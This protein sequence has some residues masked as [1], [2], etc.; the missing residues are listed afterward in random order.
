MCADG[1]Q[2]EAPAATRSTC[3][4][5][6]GRAACLL[7]SHESAHGLPARGVR[8]RRPAAPTTLTPIEERYD[9]L[10][11]QIDH[12]G[13]GRESGGANNN[14]RKEPR[15]RGRQAGRQAGKG[16]ARGARARD[17][18]IA[19]KRE[20]GRSCRRKMAETLSEREGPPKTI[21]KAGSTLT[22]RSIDPRRARSTLCAPSPTI[23]AYP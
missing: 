3:P 4:R 20:A 18:E 11:V 7:E 17:S 8:E 5:L 16:G 9:Y 21:T 10:K 2:E 15:Q 6:A 14:R 12:C 19:R 22:S 1:G 13:R 23:T